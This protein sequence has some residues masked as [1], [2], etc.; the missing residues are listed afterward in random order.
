MN[1][2]IGRR[3]C[4]P[5]QVCVNTQ[6]SYKCQREVADEGPVDEPE[7]STPSVDEPEPHLNC[8]TGFTYNRRSGQ[9]DGL[10][11][12]YFSILQKYKAFLF[13]GMTN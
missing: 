2:C 4:S 3:V 7:A 10:I 9:C 12:F 11:C 8:G 5:G 1:E 6:G 13:S